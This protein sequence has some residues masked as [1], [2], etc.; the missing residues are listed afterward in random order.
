MILDCVSEF[1]KSDYEFEKSYSDPATSDSQAQNQ[2]T[3][4]S[5][6]AGS[7]SLSIQ[8]PLEMNLTKFCH[9]APY[10]R[11]PYRRNASLDVQPIGIH[12]H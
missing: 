5:A 3:F 7:E 12:I 10:G 1:E 8:P 4:S 9:S 2:I 6:W 11:A